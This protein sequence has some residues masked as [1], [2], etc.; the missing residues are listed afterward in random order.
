MFHSN[1]AMT[2]DQK[3]ASFF[4]SHWSTLHH[5]I[6]ANF[7]KFFTVFW[8]DSTMISIILIC[9]CIGDFKK[10]H[11]DKDSGGFHFSKTFE[12]FYDNLLTKKNQRVFLWQDVGCEKF[13][14][15]ATYK[16]FGFLGKA[17]HDSIAPPKKYSLVFLYE[18]I[19]HRISYVEMINVLVLYRIIFR[20]NSPSLPLKLKKSLLIL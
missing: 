2:I 8:A 7:A 13:I 5:L 20:I 17:S 4:N 12:M 18:Q 16:A 19:I 6:R 11:E 9:H 10:C 15:K 1:A 3:R 14:L